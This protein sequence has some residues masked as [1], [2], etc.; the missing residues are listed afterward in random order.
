YIKEGQE[1]PAGM[2]VKEGPRGGRYYETSAGRGRPLGEPPKDWTPK[3]GDRVRIRLPGDD[4]NGRLA[5]VT[6]LGRAGD[7]VSAYIQG[8]GWEGGGN[9]VMSSG[10]LVPAPY[11]TTEKKEM[12]ARDILIA[13][14][15]ETS[16]SATSA[17]QIDIETNLEYDVYDTEAG[18]QLWVKKEPREDK[19]W[20][21]TKE[22]AVSL[23]AFMRALL[24]MPTD[25]MQ[26]MKEGAQRIVFSPVG[27]P[28]DRKTSQMIGRK[29]TSA[30]SLKGSDRVYVWPASKK[31]DA[32]RL[33]QVLTHEAGHIVDHLRSNLG[34]QYQDGL[35]KFWADLQ[36]NEG[37]LL[38]ASI[39]E[40][41]AIE[42]ER[43]IP[44]DPN[45]WQDDWGRWKNVELGRGSP[46]A[47][48]YWPS[49]QVEKPWRELSQA[50]KHLIEKNVQNA[51]P[52]SRYAST[53]EK[54]YYAEAYA[55]YQLGALPGDHIMYAHFDN[56]ER[57]KQW[58]QQ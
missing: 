13:E 32:G 33:A 15:G 29:F 51:L 9:F 8:I 48:H 31:F 56:L 12:T 3:I 34:A 25:A 10:Q 7:Q 27:N 50:A 1:A 40:Q 57:T 30:A 41:E 5:R 47:L 54:E 46:G 52:V 58:L 28:H 43:G 53:N 35:R 44:P 26:A 21:V 16:R 19:P 14:F 55:W 23:E 22:S 6:N 39:R 11:S 42:V 20:V 36:E 17:T 2:H 38:P 45:K 24:E 49:I 37:I 4:W 18:P